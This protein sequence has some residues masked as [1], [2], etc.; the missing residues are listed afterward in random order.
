MNDAPLAQAD[1]WRR[2]ARSQY[3][4]RTY[5]DSDADI[6][7]AGIRLPQ[8]GYDAIYSRKAEDSCSASS[9]FLLTTSPIDTT[10]IN[11]P[12]STTGI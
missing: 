6:L 4:C 11:S 3:R 5:S 2:I 12:F 7:A 10:P 8:K 1:I 9:I